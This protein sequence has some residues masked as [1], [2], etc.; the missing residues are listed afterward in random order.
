[1]N[2]LY[3][4]S[5]AL[6][7]LLSTFFYRTLFTFRYA[8][9]HYQHGDLYANT[10]NCSP[11]LLDRLSSTTLLVSP[12][13]KGLDLLGLQEPENEILEEPEEHL[14]MDMRQRATRDRGGERPLQRVEAGVSVAMRGNCKRA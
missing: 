11:A 14:P 1:M 2:M 8:G 5:F 7:I 3:F 4:L 6:K 10:L 12:R 9:P 13:T